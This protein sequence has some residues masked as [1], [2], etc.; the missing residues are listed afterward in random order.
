MGQ[1]E[2]GHRRTQIISASTAAF[3]IV[4][5]YVVPPEV[6]PSFARGWLLILREVSYPSID[7]SVVVSARRT[8]TLVEVTS[9]PFFAVSAPPFEAE[10][11]DPPADVSQVLPAIYRN[12]SPP[13]SIE[14]ALAKRQVVISAVRLVACA[15]LQQWGHRSPEREGLCSSSCS[16]SPS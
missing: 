15:T 1:V 2:I 10:T 3:G 16:G 4:V 14:A 12:N 9:M 11:N 8:L 13:H 5:E 7:G 6:L